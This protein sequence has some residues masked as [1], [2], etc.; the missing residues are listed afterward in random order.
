MRAV[1]TSRG[2]SHEHVQALPG[3]RLD[4]VR[5]DAGRRADGDDLHRPVPQEGVEVRERHGAVAGRQ[6]LDAAG[7]AAAD[8]DHAQIGHCR[9]GAGVRVGDAASPENPDVPDHVSRSGGGPCAETERAD[10]GNAPPD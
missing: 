8:R 6:R 2:F 9:R 4:V 7:V 5:V 1:V 3:R 10:S